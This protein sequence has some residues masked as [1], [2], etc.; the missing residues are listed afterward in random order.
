MSTSILCRIVIHNL[1]FGCFLLTVHQKRVFCTFH[2]QFHHAQ[3]GIWICHFWP[4][5]TYWI[6]VHNLSFGFFLLTLRQKRVFCEDNNRI[7]TSHVMVQKLVVF[8]HIWARSSKVTHFMSSVIIHRMVSGSIIFGFSHVLGLQK[9]C[10]RKGTSQLIMQKL[11]VFHH[12]WARLS[13]ITHS[14]SKWV[15]FHQIWTWIIQNH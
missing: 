13:K 14:T 5:R 3:N 4:F 1:S 7:G 2:E 15:V 9:D 6:V 10:C 12:I 8:H 11:V